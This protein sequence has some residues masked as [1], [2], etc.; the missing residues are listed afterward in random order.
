MS[1]LIIAFWRFN[2]PT[3]FSRKFRQQF[4]QSPSDVL[5]KDFALEEPRVEKMIRNIQTFSSYT[6]WLSAPQDP[7]L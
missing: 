5:G 2:E 6:S 3:S 4:G 1:R 7:E